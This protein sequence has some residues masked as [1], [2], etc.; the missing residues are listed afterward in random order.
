MYYIL[1]KSFCQNDFINFLDFFLKENKLAIERSLKMDSL[2]LELQK[3]LG[4]SGLTGTSMLIQIS[5]IILALIWFY[6]KFIKNSQSE[7]TVRGILFFLTI[8]WITAE[9]FSFMRLRILSALLKNLILL[10]ILSFIV[11]FQPE[12]RRLMARLGNSLNMLSQSKKKQMTNKLVDNLIQCIDYWQKNKTGVLLVF[13]NQDPVSSV[14]TGGVTLNAEMSPELLINLFFKNT[15]LHDGAVVVKNGMVAMAAVVLPLSRE[16]DLNWKYGT[17]HRAA[18]GISE[19][20][21]ALVLVVSEENGDISLVKGGQIKT[22][23]TTEDLQKTLLTFF[24]PLIK[25]TS[26]GSIWKRLKDLIKK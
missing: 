19:N 20:T 22:F 3:Y 13:E 15:P 14:S 7:K 21:D 9:L 6:I 23:H 25:K 2:R 17:R 11:I 5:I 26:T 8:I 10:I 16:V 4:V 24:A 18:M 1:K 12:L